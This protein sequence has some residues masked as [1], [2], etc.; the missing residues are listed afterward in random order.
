MTPE[1]ELRRAGE[2]QQVLGSSVFQE[3]CNRI[4]EG[5]AAQRRGVPIT[6]TE[7]HTALILTEQLW[8]NVRNWIEQVA[9]TGKFA[10]IELDRQRTLRQR[11]E[12]TVRIWRR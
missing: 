12:E 7:M 11:A 1:E 5:L 4:D 10:Q 8:S 9:Q 2:A 3:A 6:A